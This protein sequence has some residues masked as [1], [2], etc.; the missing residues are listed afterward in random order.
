MPVEQEMKAKSKLVD[1]K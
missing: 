1:F